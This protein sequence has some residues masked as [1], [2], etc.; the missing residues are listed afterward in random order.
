MCANLQYYYYIPIS[1]LD[2][3]I[4]KYAKIDYIYIILFQISYIQYRNRNIKMLMKTILTL[5]LGVSQATDGDGTT[6][7][8]VAKMCDGVALDDDLNDP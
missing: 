4:V 5:F 3:I 8:S 7:W 1:L 6:T 2:L